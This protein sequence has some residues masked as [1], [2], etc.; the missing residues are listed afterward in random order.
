MHK[1]IRRMMLLGSGAALVASVAMAFRPALPDPQQLLLLVQRF[2]AETQPETS[3]LHLNQDAYAAGETLWFKAYVVGAG[4]HQLDTLSRVLY[5]DVVTPQRTVAFCRTLRLRQGMAEGDIVLPDTLRTGIYTIRAYTSWMR[6]W[7]E[8]LLFTRRVPVWQAVAPAEGAEPVSMLRQAALAR[9]TSR[10]VAAA[11]QPD[12]Q[13]FPEGGEYVQGAQSIV[14]VKAVTASG[15]GIALRGVIL[16][17]RKQRVAEFST[18]AL[19]MSSFAFTPQPGRKYQA[20]VTL[21]DDT[22]AQYPLPAAQPSGWLLTVRDLGSRYM[23]Y[24]RRPGGTGPE[25][26]QVVAH[27]R[28]T[29]VYAGA[30]TIVPGETYAAPIPKNRLPAGLVH[31]T[32]LDGQNTA[33]AERLVFSLPAAQATAQ[34]QF[35]KAAYGARQPVAVE[36]TLRDAAGQPVAADVSVAV[37]AQVGLPEQGRQETTMQAHL[38]LTSELRGYVENPAWYFRNTTPATRQALDDLL[39][40]QGWSRFVWRQVTSTEPAINSFDFPLER[41]LSLGGQLV[42]GS[43]PVPNGPLLLLRK[44][45]PEV[46]ELQANDQGYFLLTGFSGTDT[47]QVL[48]QART[49]KGGNNLQLRLWDRWPVPGTT[50]WHPRPPLAAFTDLENT[51]TAY[52]LQSRR[53]QVLERQFRPD[54]TSGIVLRNVTIKGRRPD[55][56]DPRSLHGKASAVLHTKDI[57]EAN[58]FLNVFELMRG[59]L[60]GVLVNG[61]GLNYSVTIRGLSSITQ[62]SDALYL[63]NGMPL[64]ANGLLSVPVQDVERIEVLKGAEAGIYGSRGSNGV[65]AVFTKEGSDTSGRAGLPGVATRRLPAYYRTR[66]FYAPRYEVPAPA[67]RPDPRLTTL[68]WQPM[69]HVPASGQARF[70]F[71]TADAAGAFLAR[72]E[73][74]TAG[75]EPVVAQARLVVEANR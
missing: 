27:V 41:T 75:G 48:L 8:E 13:F 21:P 22:E 35:D 62:S 6:N 12:V 51:V 61:G 2:Y 55:P 10:V 15:Q 58:T 34:L 45:V 36:V 9:Q 71:Y 64:D 59:R 40:T 67:N 17:D 52:G 4:T 43:K 72:L 70:S 46:M 23:V 25:P 14:G 42:R 5:V 7:P 37:A 24:V 60:A 16:D 26:L 57:P 44:G 47:A 50:N 20:Q 29:P 73:G 49:P 38:L 39:L 65:V 3:Y 28:G 31:V 30:G 56:V 11:A 63:L 32:L 66:E 18:P 69:L 68:F 33:R 19:G 53:Q 54:T 74:V 1:T